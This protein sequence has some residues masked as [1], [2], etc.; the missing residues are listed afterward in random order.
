LSAAVS[1]CACSHPFS[2]FPVEPVCRHQLPSL[3]RLFPLCLAGPSYQHDEPF[4]RVPAPSLYAMG[5]PY[6]LRLPREPSWT[7]VHARRDLRPRRLPTCPSFLLS[8]A[9]TRT[10]SPVSFR[11]SPLSLALCSHRSRS[12]ET[13]A[14]HAG[15]PARRKPCQATPSFA[16]R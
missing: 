16:P 11:A 12:P 4:L 8:T 1:L 10:C 5:P 7:S 14:R 2:L 6:Q 13:C 9:R 3:A 15:H